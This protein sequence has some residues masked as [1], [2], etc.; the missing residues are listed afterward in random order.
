[1]RFARLPQLAHD[2]AADVAGSAG[3]QDAA[4]R[5]DVG[6]GVLKDARYR[7]G[8][9]GVG[10]VLRT[11]RRTFKLVTLRSSERLRRLARPDE[12]VGLRR[13]LVLD[14]HFAQQLQRPR[15]VEAAHRSQNLI[16]H[17]LDPLP[18]Q[19]MLDCAQDHRVLGAR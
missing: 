11:M 3:D 12:I 13:R 9:V 18:G 19:G 7:S 16:Q 17:P 1:M 4:L 2:V 6:P 5:Q 8:P 10:L 15:A 14:D